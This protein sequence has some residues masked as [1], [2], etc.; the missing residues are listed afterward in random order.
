MVFHFPVSSELLGFS[1]PSRGYSQ[2]GEGTWSC[3]ARCGTCRRVQGQGCPTG[4]V[5]DVAYRWT[6]FPTL[7][8]LLC[9]CAG[10]YTCFPTVRHRKPT[11]TVFPGSGTGGR[12]AQGFVYTLASGFG[13]LGPEGVIWRVTPPFLS[14]PLQ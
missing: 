7:L 14:A 11:R 6:R 12:G 9:F 3:V 5:T 2:A 4:G 1:P 13:E 10:A 8:L